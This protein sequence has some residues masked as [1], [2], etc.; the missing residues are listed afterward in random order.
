M[1]NFLAR[2]QSKISEFSRRLQ[3][4]NVTL[5]AL[6]N[7]KLNLTY[8]F[9]YYSFDIPIPAKKSE[10]TIIIPIHDHQLKIII[11]YM[12]KQVSRNRDGNYANIPV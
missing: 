5:F 10:N 1:L 8:T 2:N 3:T 4:L 9:L 11:Q 6:K 7:N 12:V